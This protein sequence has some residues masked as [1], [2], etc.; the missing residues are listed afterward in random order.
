VTA[1][2]DNV[3]VEKMLNLIAESLSLHVIRNGNEFTLEGQ[4]CR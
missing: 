1:N 2:F 4:G 3:S